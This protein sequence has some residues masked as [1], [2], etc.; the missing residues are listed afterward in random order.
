[1]KLRLGP[2]VGTNNN[3]CHLN[4]LKIYFILFSNYLVQINTLK[5]RNSVF[6]KDFL[7]PRL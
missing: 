5:I 2:F 7:N 4:D 1:M 6:Y 3:K